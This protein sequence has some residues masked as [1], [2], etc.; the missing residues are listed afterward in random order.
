M[1]TVRKMCLEDIDG[2]MEVDRDCFSIPWSRE[3]FMMELESSLS[4][5][6]VAVDNDG[7][8]GY[9]GF[10]MV[11]DQVEITNI[12][13][14]GKVR[15][16]G[17]GKSILEALIKLALIGGGKVVNLDVRA[18]NEAAKALYYSYGFKLVGMRRGYY[19]KP[20]EDALLLTLSLEEGF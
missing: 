17:I 2:V 19:Q 10:Y 8:L 14:M 16:K 15:G 18:S 5:Y 11:L 12:A 7:V 13:V 1:I 4:T 6:V 20:D 3:S 9:G